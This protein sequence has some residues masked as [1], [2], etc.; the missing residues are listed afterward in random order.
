MILRNY[1]LFPI[2]GFELAIHEPKYL[3]EKPIKVDGK[4]SNKWVPCSEHDFCGKDVVYK[5]D[6]DYDEYFNNWYL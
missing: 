5:V 4:L 6:K 2:Y 3:C 1:S